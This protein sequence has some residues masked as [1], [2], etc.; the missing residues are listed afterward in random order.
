[1]NIRSEKSRDFR[2]FIVFEKL[3]FQIVFRA[4]ENE[5]PVFSASFGL[6]IVFEKLRFRDGF[7]WTVGLTGEIKPLCVV[8]F[9]SP[10]YC[11]RGLGDSSLSSAREQ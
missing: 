10:A 7:V 8:T 9:L 11:G 5:M 6:E 2:D 1:M 3:R 4:H